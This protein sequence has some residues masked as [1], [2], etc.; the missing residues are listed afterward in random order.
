MNNIFFETDDFHNAASY[1]KERIAETQANSPFEEERNKL[2]IELLDYIKSTAKKWDEFCAYN[3]E[4]LRSPLLDALH[5]DR[6]QNINE[7]LIFSL[8]F[9]FSAEFNISSANFRRMNIGFAQLSEI[10]NISEKFFR[11]GIYNIDNFPEPN[12]KEIQYT[13]YQQPTLTV[14]K[15]LQQ[16][17]TDSY[18]DFIEEQR[19][20]TDEMKALRQ[21][22]D[23]KT[24]IVNHLNN[25]LGKQKDA[26]N[27]IGLH[28]AFA[29]LSAAKSRELTKTKFLLF[30]MGASLLFPLAWEARALSNLV[31]T[32]DILGHLL[33][34]I[35]ILSLTLILIYFF[36]VILNNYN[37]VRAQL[38]QINLRKN[39]CQFIHNYAEYSKDI[40]NEK[41]NPLAKFEDIIFSN[42]MG[43]DEKTPST[44]DG[45][46]QLASIIKAVKGN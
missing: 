38:M 24:K 31:G 43:S 21:E 18:N 10:F 28:N 7:G 13:L 23:E 35:P 34:S 9:S 8:L 3:I 29:T 17:N 22:M 37:S 11:F 45:I 40:I 6:N 25:E 33:K 2:I 12:K 14:K 42:I 19:I 44:F 46:E 26:F 20:F 39:L 5:P 32:G 15:C 1:C 30:L 36:R 41:V 16:L 4:H 27:F